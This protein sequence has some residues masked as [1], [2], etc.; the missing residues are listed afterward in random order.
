MG[1]ALSTVSL[2]GFGSLLAR[3]TWGDS[4]VVSAESSGSIDDDFEVPEAE[5]S[6]T[7]GELVA[8]ARSGLKGCC[9]GSKRLAMLVSIMIFSAL[10]KG[11]FLL[12]FIGVLGVLVVAT[13]HLFSLFPGL[14]KDWGGFVA[15][16]GR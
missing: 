10:E 8:L 4:L 11:L 3:L 6:R 14:E 13:P 15:F 1:T 2:A 12:S 16:K 5:V 9:S 7:P